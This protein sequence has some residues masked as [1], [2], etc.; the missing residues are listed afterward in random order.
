MDRSLCRIVYLNV[1][2]SYVIMLMD[3][4][5]V[6]MEI[7]VLLIVVKVSYFFFELLKKYKWSIGCNIK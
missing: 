4:V 7:D 1:K 3:F 2:I 5:F 6:E